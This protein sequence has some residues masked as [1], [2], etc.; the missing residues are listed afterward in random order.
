M[1]LEHANTIPISEILGKLDLQPLR[2]EG[3]V[4]YYSS[5]WG[6]KH[7]T[8]LTVHTITNRWSDP[9]MSDGTL[10]EWVVHYL[11]FCGEA[12]TE[13]DAL[14]W[15]T[16]MSVGSS[17]LVA[18]PPGQPPRVDLRHK[19][20]IQYPGLLHYLH[21]EGIALPLA[22]QYLK[23]IHARNRQTGK[24]FIAL[25]LLT[26]DGGFA[27]RTAY[28]KRSIGQ[29]AISFIRGRMPKPKGIH[30]FKEVLDFL[31]VLSHLNRTTLDE[32]VIILNAWSC[33]AQVPAYIH[34]YGYQTM[35]TWLDNTEQGQQ[36][37]AYVGQFLQIE[38]NTRHQPMNKLYAAH[39]CVHTWYR[40]LAHQTT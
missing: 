32:D 26:V 22:R 27:L 34:Q 16:N 14:R 5:L 36:A 31:S 8:T 10:V 6:R 33:L 29:P 25:G 39:H 37:T 11:R 17:G 12:H 7:Q 30:L 1:D 4:L 20:T 35:Y 13:R 9:N 28:L 19:K 18:A 38:A 3:P 23:E 21:R 40:H 24:D 15:I 2:S